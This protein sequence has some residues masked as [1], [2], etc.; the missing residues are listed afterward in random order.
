MTR[1]RNSN[2]LQEWD[3]TQ[4]TGDIESDVNRVLMGKHE[5]EYKYKLLIG[6]AKLMPQFD[7]KWPDEERQ[8]WQKSHR[9]I[10]D[11]GLTLA[12]AQDELSPDEHK[13]LDAY[14]GGDLEKVIRLTL[15][16]LDNNR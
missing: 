7:P 2:D 3:S 6:I 13:L 9:V 14:R 11:A 12:M 15:Q 4:E 8:K 16:R 10:V 1:T 5:L